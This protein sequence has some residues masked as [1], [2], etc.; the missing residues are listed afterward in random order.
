MNDKKSYTKS[1]NEGSLSKK[2][3]NK[4]SDFMT[5]RGM[6]IKKSSDVILE[7]KKITFY[8]TEAYGIKNF[9]YLNSNFHIL[10]PAI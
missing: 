1:L 7:Q 6:S 4:I 9:L 10:L 2:A 8:S 5:F 3:V